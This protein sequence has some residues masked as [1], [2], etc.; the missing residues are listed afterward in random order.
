MK[1]IVR[2]PLAITV[3]AA[4]ISLGMVGVHAGTQCVQFVRKHHSAATLARWA[5]W[6]KAHPNWH[7]KKTP[8]EIEAQLNFACS[9]PVAENSV[10]DSINPI[11]IAGFD[12]PVEMLPPVDDAPPLVAMN[13][14]PRDLFPDAP[15]TSLVSPPMYSPQYPSLFGSFPSPPSHVQTGP[16]VAPEPSTW[17]LLATSLLAMGAL[18]SRRPRAATVVARRR[19]F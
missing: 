18:A 14:Q 16:G 17:M 13:E 9:V 8:Q 4:A 1:P 12:L 10:D 3:T 19:R 15:P 5:A 7:P 2:I 6:D 11:D